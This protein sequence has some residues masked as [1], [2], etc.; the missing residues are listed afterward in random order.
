MAG[1]IVGHY[2]PDHI[3]GRAELSRRSKKAIRRKEE[4][5]RD[6]AMLGYLRCHAGLSS[7]TELRSKKMRTQMHHSNTSKM[8]GMVIVM[9]RSEKPVCA[10]TTQAVSTAMT[11]NTPNTPSQRVATELSNIAT[12]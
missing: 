11:S 4:R 2:D 5:L 7:A 8:L 3:S 10:G 1:W 6:D 12:P 9:A